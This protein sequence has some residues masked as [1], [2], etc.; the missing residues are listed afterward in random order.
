MLR[1]N[2]YGIFFTHADNLAKITRFPAVTVLSDPWTGT[3]NKLKL[4]LSVGCVHY[5]LI[6]EISLVQAPYQFVDT[7]KHP[8]FPL[9][10]WRHKHEFHR[11]GGKTFMQDRIEIESQLP[12]CILKAWLDPM[13]RSRAKQIRRFIS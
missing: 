8:P 12:S 6:T 5:E 10:Y 9:R 1:S 3:G 2:V 4:K 13:F 11:S 7:I